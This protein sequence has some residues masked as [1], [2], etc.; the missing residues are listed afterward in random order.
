MTVPEANAETTTPARAISR[1][2]RRRVSSG[3]PMARAEGVDGAMGQLGEEDEAGG[4]DQQAP[5]PEVDA[6]ECG[7]HH[8]QDAAIGVCEEAG[9]AADRVLETAQSGGELLLR[10]PP[11][12]PGSHGQRLLQVGG[13]EPA[14][15]DRQET[16]RESAVEGILIHQTFPSHCV[17]A[18]R[19]SNW[20]MPS[21]DPNRMFGLIRGESMNANI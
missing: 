21:P 18:Y 7:G 5:A 20:L 9:V 13:V 6:Q 11:A 12:G 15:G 4:D 14:V 1:A 10:R 8:D 3:S 17:G 16:P 19:E 2:I